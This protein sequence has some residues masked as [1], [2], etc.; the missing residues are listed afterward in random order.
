M[1]EG[2]AALLNG[3]SRGMGLAIARGILDRGGKV[4]ITGRKQPGLDAALAELDAGNRAIGVPGSSADSAHRREA[5]RRTIETFGSLDLLVNNAGTN[6]QYG[7]LIE[8]ETSRVEKVFEVNVFAVLGWM[9][10]AWKAWMR[11]HGGAVLNTAS[12]SA[13]RTPHKIGAYNVS[14][15]AVVHLT[16]QMAS[17][18]APAVRVNAIAPALI[19]TRFA[20]AVW[21]DREA[22]WAKVYPMKRLGEPRDVVGMACLLLS[23]EAS[24]I[25][26]ETVVIDGGILVAGS[27]LR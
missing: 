10:D 14:K 25:T 21:Q 3:A 12:T 13:Y 6:P 9:Q 5:V 27:L 22:D 26:G 23:D 11:D 7:P 8:A 15:A 19:K 24:W 2:K 17:E 18:L 1:F 16:R 20:S 4:C